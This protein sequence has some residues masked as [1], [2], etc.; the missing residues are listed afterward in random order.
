L[1]ASLMPEE[2]V[3]TVTSL[4]DNALYYYGDGALEYKL[5]L[6]E[7]M[8]GLSEDAQY[9]LRELKSKGF[10]AREV[11]LKDSRGR[12]RTVRV[13][14]RGP[15]CFAG[16][17]TKERVYEDNANR[18]LLLYRDETEG[19]Q[20]AVMAAQ[21]RAAAG[22]VDEWALAQLREQFKD[23]QMLLKAVKVV[24]PYAEQ[25]V[26]PDKVFKPLRTNAHYLKFIEVITFYH[27]LQ[28]PIKKNAQGENY[29]ETSL[30]DIEWANK[31]LKDILLAKSDELNWQLRQFLENLKTWLQSNGKKS[32]GAMELR[33]AFRMAPSTQIKYLSELQRYGLLKVLGG[34]RYKGYEYAL[35]NYDDY[36]ALE[37]EIESAF[38][39]VFS[40]IK[41]KLE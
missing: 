21:R 31:L 32:F 39:K 35:T 3:V 41:S 8:D 2:E 24:N 25:L 23:C 11:P 40:T 14:V 7:D 30:E 16:C 6:I 29:I 15:I 18:C 36:E 38:D 27:Q 9:A 33:R 37:N 26:L 4:S 34:S 17:T 22:L 1:I 12:L 13:L 19:H 28:R 5:F 10:V 20:A